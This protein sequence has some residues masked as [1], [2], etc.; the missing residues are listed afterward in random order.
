MLQDRWGAGDPSGKH[1]H[2][3]T[4]RLASQGI[5]ALVARGA[6]K[7]VLLVPA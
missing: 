4:G 7:S 6:S 2:F 5:G 1:L 3:V